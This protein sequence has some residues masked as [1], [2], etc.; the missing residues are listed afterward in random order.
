M[1]FFRKLAMAAIVSSALAAPAW[2]GS[3]SDDIPAA[4]EAFAAAFNKGDGATVASLYSEDGALLPPDGKRVDGRAAIQT[5]WQGAIDGGLGN[6][7]LTTVEI[8]ES[9]DYA[10]EVGGL[11]LDAPGEGGAKTKVEGKYIVVWKKNGEG[12]WQLHRDIW[13]MG[14]AQ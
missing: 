10:H 3:A 1:G 12:T 2:A 4:S 8:V 5:F 11:T 7:T 6:L 14:A 13:N 9:G